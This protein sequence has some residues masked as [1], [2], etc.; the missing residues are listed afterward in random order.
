MSAYKGYFL[1]CIVKGN[2]RRWH[3]F[4]DAGEQL[5]GVLGYRSRAAC[6]R[7]C[8]ADIEKKAARETV[9]AKRN[10]SSLHLS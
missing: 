9:F 1:S 8:D 3:A 7:W 2:S 6:R 10:D 5:T 4:N